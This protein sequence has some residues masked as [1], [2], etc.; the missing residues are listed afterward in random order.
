MYRFAQPRL[1]P[2]PPPRAST[3]TT[4]QYVIHH[5]FLDMRTHLL[6]HPLSLPCFLLST[7]PPPFRSAPNPRGDFFTLLFLT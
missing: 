5:G 4:R 6:D 1:Y 7:L 2:F 3:H